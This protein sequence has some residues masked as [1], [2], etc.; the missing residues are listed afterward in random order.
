M[1]NHSFS[2]ESSIF[3]AFSFAVLSLYYYIPEYSNHLH[4]LLC[5]FPD[6]YSFNRHYLHLSGSFL[7]YTNERLYTPITIHFYN[8]LPIIFT[9]CMNH[10]YLQGNFQEI[11]QEVLYT[12][13]YFFLIVQMS[14][15]DQ[16]ELPTLNH[17]SST[18]KV[19]NDPSKVERVSFRTLYFKYA[20]KRDIWYLCLGLV[21]KG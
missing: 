5:T 19:D 3:I 16:I 20:T 7:P 18:V 15:V 8:P 9:C 17:E 11:S 10:Y 12:S 4:S 13:S 21:C 2:I 14:K 1:N 6:S